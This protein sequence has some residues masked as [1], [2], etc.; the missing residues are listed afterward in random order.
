MAA[1]DLVALNLRRLRTGLGWRQA[2]LAERMSRRA[3]WTASVVAWAETGRRKISAEELGWLCEVLHIGAEQFWAGDHQVLTADGSLAVPAALLARSVAG[4]APT[5][6]EPLTDG[7]AEARDDERKA[8]R[9]L[10]LTPD[11]FRAVV[12]AMYGRPFHVERDSRIDG[13]GRT[14]RSMQALRGHATR[15]LVAEIE[16]AIQERGLEG[17]LNRRKRSKR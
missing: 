4:K 13:D 7:E 12:H 6:A 16:S 10:E 15:T 14:A 3:G 9:R 1:N 5:G 2:D 8:A 11:V 17:V